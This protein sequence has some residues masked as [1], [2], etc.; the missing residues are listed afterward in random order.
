MSTRQSQHRDYM[1]RFSQYALTFSKRAG[2]GSA[3]ITIRRASSATSPTIV[4]PQSPLQ[5]TLREYQEECIQ[6]VLSYLQK[7]HKRL[8]ISLATGGGKTVGISSQ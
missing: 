3:R 1:F 8:G 7:G 2:I 4:S 6:S 5:T